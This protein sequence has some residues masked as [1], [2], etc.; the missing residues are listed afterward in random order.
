[1]LQEPSQ[2]QILSSKRYGTG[3][4]VDPNWISLDPD[5]ALQVI[6]DPN[7][8]LKYTI[9][10]KTFK[11]FKIFYGTLYGLVRDQRRISHFEV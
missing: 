5:P 10:R 6:P 7:P 2:K 1:M 4:M 8:N 11:Q 9:Q 3:T